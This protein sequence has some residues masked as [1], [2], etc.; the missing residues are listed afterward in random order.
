VELTVGS[1]R[2]PSVPT[3]ALSEQDEQARLFVVVDGR[4]EER[5]VALGPK[6]AERSS[7]TRGVKAGELVVVSERAGL[8]NGRRVR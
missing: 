8:G 3:G 7:V 5:L 1:E 4:L 2:L 6:V